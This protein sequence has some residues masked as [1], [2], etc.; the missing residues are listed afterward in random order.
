[1]LRLTLK[2]EYFTNLLLRLTEV[3]FPLI[4]VLYLVRTKG[5]DKY[6]EIAAQYVWYVGTVFFVNLGFDIGTSDLMRNGVR[7]RLIAF[8]VLLLR[9]LVSV[10]LLPVLIY[11]TEMSFFTIVFI[12]FDSVIN[13]RFLLINNGMLNRLFFPT[14][15]LRVFQLFYI[16]KLEDFL[17]ADAY[18]LSF[19]ISSILISAYIWYI[20]IRSVNGSFQIP[21]TQFASSF[22]SSHRKIFGV[23][24]NYTPLQIANYLLLRGYLLVGSSVLPGGTFAYLE[25][26]DRFFSMLKLPLNAISEI[27]LT[28]SLISNAKLSFRKLHWVLFFIGFLLIGLIIIEY[29]WSLNGDGNKLNITRVWFSVLVILLFSENVTNFYHMPELINKGMRK[30]LLVSALLSATVTLLLAVAFRVMSGGPFLL[31]VLLLPYFVLICYRELKLR[32]YV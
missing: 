26:L 30:F 10:F 12:L 18:V 24:F 22:Q 9:L 32:N 5:P 7:L 29:I 27:F 19:A 21:W 25:L 28:Q 15:L 20:C 17:T 1:M 14:L 8:F 2:N 11:M 4:I 3:V 13:T 6:G 16:Y 31:T 23:L